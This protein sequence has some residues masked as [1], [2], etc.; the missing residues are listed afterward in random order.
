MTVQESERFSDARQKSCPR[1]GRV[2]GRVE[3]RECYFSKLI[4]TS[5]YVS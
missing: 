4:P 5:S 2:L 1:S 3:Q